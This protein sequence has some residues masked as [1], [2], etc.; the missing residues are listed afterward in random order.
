MTGIF[1]ISIHAP[2]AGSDLSGK[3]LI[4]FSEDFNPRSPCGE[5]PSRCHLPDLSFQISIHAPH[6]GSDNVLSIHSLMAFYFNPRSP[7]G[8]RRYDYV[9]QCRRIKF[10]STL[11]MR[12]ATLVLGHQG[13]P[14]PI[15]IH[16]PHAGSDYPPMIVKPAPWIFQSTL[17][18][19]GATWM[20]NPMAVLL[21]FQS[22]LPMRGATR[23]D[24][25]H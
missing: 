14:V 10:Q 1:P 11:P 24:S 18:M 8:E 3:T 22:T 2:H 4:H 13:I 6:A 17:P 5:R 21:L 12:G 23:A 19:R 15:S 20:E 7:C 16:A 9:H 25:Y